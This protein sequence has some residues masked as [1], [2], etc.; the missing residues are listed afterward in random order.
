MGGSGV[1]GESSEVIRLTA[2]TP[3]PPVVL[4]LVRSEIE[5]VFFF[6]PPPFMFA[7][8]SSVLCTIF[9]LPPVHV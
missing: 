1:A 8:I 2:F 7:A 6:L 3:L 5:E 9:M 4:F